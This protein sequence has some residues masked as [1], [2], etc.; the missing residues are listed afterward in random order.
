MDRRTFLA[1]SLAAPLA[2]TARAEAA[3]SRLLYVVCPGIRDYPEF[4]G[5]GVLVFDIDAGHTF[6][7]RIGTDASTV[8]RPRNVKGVVAS[9]ATRK[10]HFTTPE[11]LYCVDLVSGKTDWGKE[12]P[13]GCD[14]LAGTPDGKTLYVPSFEKDVWNV[15]DA[16]TG[17]V[18]A[19]IETRSGAHNTICGLDGTRVYLAGLKSPFLFVADTR[20][21]KVVE[22]VGPFA[23]P[24]RPFTVNGSQTRC[25]VNVN[26]LL[27][28]EVG[29]LKT[30]KKVHRVE[31][32]DVKAG[33]VK[34]HGC[35]SHG[36][37]LTP[38]EKEVWVV[39]ASNERVHVFDATA[40]PP[41][42]ARSVKLREQPG[43]VTFSLDGKYAYPSTCTVSGS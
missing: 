30:G 22:K 37:G 41:K 1:A 5:A 35:P 20:T 38:D 3:V 33:V 26:G 13:Q 12:L 32:P 25:F 8:A 14:R 31:V 29:D 16:A 18:T 40:T 7:K 21:N 19:D 34:R 28:F 10:L 36:V 23:A 43:W 17:K 2:P 39:D 27:G 11:T 42:Y 6:V 9:A 15:V 4:G 24:V